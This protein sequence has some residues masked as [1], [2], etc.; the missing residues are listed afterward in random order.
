MKKFAFFCE[1]KMY[2]NFGS[3]IFTNKIDLNAPKKA[4]IFRMTMF[5]SMSES[6]FISKLANDLNISSNCSD[7]IEKLVKHLETMNFYIIFEG[8]YFCSFLSEMAFQFNE[9]PKFYQKITIISSCTYSTIP[10][11]IITGKLEPLE[12]E[13]VL[14]IGFFKFTLKNFKQTIE[15]ISENSFNSLLLHLSMWPAK[16]N[17]LNLN[18]SQEIVEKLGI[19]LGRISRDIIY[20]VTNG[21]NVKSYRFFKFLMTIYRMLDNYYVKASQKE[22]S[23]L[24]FYKISFMEDFFLNLECKN[25]I[26]EK[27]MIKF[28][29]VKLSL[30]NA[31]SFH[32]IAESQI[33]ICEKFES[34]NAELNYMLNIQKAIYFNSKGLFNNVLEIFKNNVEFEDTEQEKNFHK[35]I[36]SRSLII[37]GN[38]E[39][40]AKILSE[41][42]P[43]SDVHFMSEYF[44]NKIVL[45]NKKNEDTEILM[46]QL[47]DNSIKDKID[48]CFHLGVYLFE[49]FKYRNFIELMNRI[50]KLE[51][52]KD[53][54]SNLYSMLGKIYISFSD[55]RK[56]RLAFLKSNE[57]KIRAEN[58]K[59]LFDVD[60]YEN[61]LVGLESNYLA[62][63]DKKLTSS[64]NISLIIYYYLNSNMEKAKEYINK[65]S[66]DTLSNYEKLRFYEIAQIVYSH[67]GDLTNLSFFIENEV[68]NYFGDLALVGAELLSFLGYKEKALQIIDKIWETEQT[69]NV[70]ASLNIIKVIVYINSDDKESAISLLD[71]LYYD[72][73]NE[74]YVEFLKLC[75]GKRSSLKKARKIFAKYQNNHMLNLLDLCSSEDVEEKLEKISEIN[76][77]IFLVY[78]YLLEYNYSKYNID[79]IY[80]L[81]VKIFEFGKKNLSPKIYENLKLERKK[82]PIIEKALFYKISIKSSKCKIDALRIIFP[83]PMIR[84]K[85]TTRLIVSE[86]EILCEN[87]I[88]ISK[89]LIHIIPKKNIVTSNNN[90]ILFSIK[91][92]KSEITEL[93][94]NTA[95]IFK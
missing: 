52:S 20:Y 38:V 4:R 45:G 69:P 41:R 49:K 27:M 95:L 34:K 13:N 72:D 46:Y 18:D 91:D 88:L 44:K 35:L 57:Y 10:I 65:I 29:I 73:E 51:L 58:F 61:Y 47:F 37:C 74:G 64:V 77:E 76:L 33:Q 26:Y 48:I 55:F 23:N 50:E 39:E 54:F 89:S 36:F 71:S 25:D 68:V 11:N 92:G 66:R 14:R 56:A 83:N 60:L 93:N 78:R 24:D 28:N 84:L 15:N 87:S 53:I 1:E 2:Q 81:S 70:M 75:C 17:E 63:N 80:F 43:N 42:Q 19:N 30:A 9:N 85:P 3:K 21:I 94:T 31:C 32:D 5:N 59:F 16:H 82:I 90:L 22:F 79:T 7:I 12:D 86:K 62:I 6:Y 67:S 40:G 8:N